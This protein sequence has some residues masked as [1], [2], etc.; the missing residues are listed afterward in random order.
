MRVI[1]GQEDFPVRPSDI[2]ASKHLFDA[3]ENM[4]TEISAGHIIRLMQQKGDWEPF[5]YGELNSF[6]QK[7]CG[8]GHVGSFTFNHLLGSFRVFRR[9]ES[10]SERLDVVVREGDEKN[11]GYNIQDKDVFRVTDQFVLRSYMSGPIP[12]MKSVP[13]AETA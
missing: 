12:R 10:Y 4:E 3:F 5:T 11:D 8:A 9:G 6:Y 1:T 2:D 13:Q 7:S